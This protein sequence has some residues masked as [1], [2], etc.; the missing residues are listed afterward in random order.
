MENYMAVGSV[1]ESSHRSIYVVVNG[2]KVESNKDSFGVG[3][4][5]AVRCGNLKYVIATI[6]AVKMIDAVDS[7]KYSVQL[8]PIGVYEKSDGFSAGVTIIPS[9]TEVAFLPS[10]DMLSSIFRSEAA[11]FYLGSLDVDPNVMFR[12]D[13]NRFFGKHS[14]IVGSTGSGKSC[15]VSRILQ[16]AVGMEGGE[17]KHEYLKNSHIIIFDIHSEYKRAFSVK[18]N[19]GYNLNCLNVDDLQLPYWLLNSEELESLFIESN[20]ANSHNQISQFK[21]AVIKNKEKWN[22]DQRVTY[23][24]PVFFDIN[25]VRNY[26]S[27]LNDEVVSD[28]EGAP[29]LPKL[30]DK[31]FVEDKNRYFD[32]VL[33]FAPSSTAKEEKA[34]G[35]AFKGEFDRFL[36]RLDTKLGD[37]RLQFMLSVADEGERIGFSE[38]LKQLLGYNSKANITIVDLSGIP[39]EVLSVTV[40]LIARLIFDFAFHYSKLCHGVDKKCDVPFLLVCEEAHN[41]IPKSGGAQYNASRRSIERIAKEGRKYGLSLMV[42]SQRPSEVA[43]TIVSQCSNFISLRLTNASDQS[44]IKNIL[45]NN[46]SEACD[47]LPMLPPGVGLFVGDASPLPTVVKLPLPTPQPQSENVAV[48]D[49][50]N[51]EW[52]DILDGAL[53]PSLGGVVR[54][55][56]GLE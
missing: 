36:S 7:I 24:S 56:C 15:A 17:Y 28:K 53:H 1:V 44:Y 40:S 49:E 18:S 29:K 19:A 20:E 46:I 26:I 43:D 9:P 31:T 45:P 37:K 23:D 48:H 39:F 33:E 14:C 51:K 25:E 50:W 2:E 30:S 55:W 8:F 21:N 27:N 6:S 5:L 52:V 32:G 3:R 4:Y 42:V 12:I 41:Y 16:E 22:A 54:K 11:S 13:G 35:G 34:K 10:Q 47:T 38:V